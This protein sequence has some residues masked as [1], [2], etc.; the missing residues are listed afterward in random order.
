M[1]LVGVEAD[2]HV[3]EGKPNWGE[4]L[5]IALRFDDGSSLRL[6]VGGDGETL[7]IDRLPLEGPFDMEEYGRVEV[8]DFAGALGPGLRGA[9]LEPLRVI[10][11]REG[12]SMGL[13]LPFAGGGTVC[14]WADGDRLHWGDEAALLRHHKLPEVEPRLAEPFEG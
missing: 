5:R 4:P 6:G 7:K 9:R 12:R 13:A 11:D 14:I 1:R 8:H 2:L 10:R 3:F